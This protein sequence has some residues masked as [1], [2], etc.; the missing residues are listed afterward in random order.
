ML[1]W[2]RGSADAVAAAARSDGPAAADTEEDTVIGT[3]DVD[4]ITKELRKDIQNI[5]DSYH[6]EPAEPSILK[7][8]AVKQ[9]PRLQRIL[10]GHLDPEDQPPSQ[11]VRIFV[12]STF[13]DTEVERNWF[14]RFCNPAIAAWCESRLG[15][16]FQAVDMRW[17]VRDEASDEHTTVDLCLRELTDCQTKSR[18]LTVVSLQAQK[19]GF[20]P[21][22]ASI[23]EDEYRRLYNAVATTQEKMLLDDW[24]EHDANA[25]PPAYVLKNVSSYLG[26]DWM[27]SKEKRAQWNTIYTSIQSS[28]RAAA[29]ATL[30][31][32]RRHLYEMSV[33]EAEILK[34]ILEDPN[35]DKRCLWF[36]RNFLGLESALKDP[37]AGRFIDLHPRKQDLDKDVRSLH[38]KLTNERMAKH[39][40]ESNIFEYSLDWKPRGL[41][42][43]L[44]SEHAAYAARICRDYC[45]SVVDFIVRDI[46]ASNNDPPVVSESLVH[47]NFARTLEQEAYQPDEFAFKI[48]EYIKSDSRSPLVL[49]GAG[50]SGR[51]VAAACAVQYALTVSDIVAAR[52]VG[53][54]PA[55]AE[56]SPLL[57]SICQQVINALGV[58][59]SELAS[60]T[61][62]TAMANEWYNILEHAAATTPE[63]QIVVL[64]DGIE[65]LR[66]ADHPHD[67]LWLPGVIPPNIKLILSLHVESEA[68]NNATLAL[69][70]RS[71]Y[72]EIRPLRLENGPAVLKTLMKKYNR[73]LTPEQEKAILS[74]FNE[75][76]CSPLY[77]RI[78]AEMARTWRS[79]CCDA[80]ALLPRDLPGIIQKQFES[81]E[82]AHGELLVSRAFGYICASRFGLALSELLDLLNKDEEVLSSVFQ[83]WTP[84]DRKI[85]SLLWSR[86]E[87]DLEGVLA[88]RGEHALYGWFSRSHSIEAQKRYMAT[89]E[90]QT[91]YQEGL[92]KHF[93]SLLPEDHY[94]VPSWRHM[95]ELLWLL[96]KAGLDEDLKALLLRPG[97]MIA[98]LS[99]TIGDKLLHDVRHAW[100]SLGMTSSQMGDLILSHV[101]EAIAPEGITYAQKRP[102]IDNSAGLLFNLGALRQSVEMRKIQLEMLGSCDPPPLEHE[103]G[104][105]YA[106]LGGAYGELFE[107]EK[108]LEY[109]SKAIEI[110]RKDPATSLRLAHTLLSASLAAR[111]IGRFALAQ[112]FLE[113][114][115]QLYLPIVGEIDQNVAGAYMNMAL[116]HSAQKNYEEALAAAN[117]AI[118]IKEK[119]FGKAHPAVAEIMGN[120]CFYLHALKREDEA[121]E[122]GEAAIRIMTEASQSHTQVH[123]RLLYNV[124]FAYE[125][126]ERLE[127]ARDAY[128]RAYKIYF[129]NLG[130]HQYTADAYARTVR[131]RIRLGDKS[132]FLELPKI[133]AMELEVLKD[134]PGLLFDE[135][136]DFAELALKAN[137]LAVSRDCWA[138]ALPAAIAISPTHHMRVQLCDDLLFFTH[139]KATNQDLE[140]CTHA[141]H[142]HP[143]QLRLCHSPEKTT[144]TLNVQCTGCHLPLHLTA[145]CCK[146]CDTAWCSA[147]KPA[148]HEHE[149]EE[150]AIG[151]AAIDVAMDRSCDLCQRVVTRSLKCSD[152][153]CDFDVCSRCF[154]KI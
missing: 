153:A 118:L 48:K 129:D 87:R 77:L 107:F 70:E 131:L 147:C 144:G 60:I 59:N 124:G 8:G 150:L 123:G 97:V 49:Y 51:T 23:P 9:S 53:V 19:Y 146:S 74:R 32:E 125:S 112:E 31:P 4:V 106:N 17:G 56:I 11:I 57:L 30:S 66:A 137:E 114:A 42:P 65:Q 47:M 14:M 92:I 128:G 55:S 67:M 26:P 43:D 149:V 13:T 134:Q 133:L 38:H 120:K 64:I 145:L 61:T 68:Y 54:T 29:Q 46:T 41:R 100:F 36:R 72:I 94:A 83:H 88:L 104:S 154:A 101:R 18:S 28:L 80:E 12:S 136:Y 152:P 132:G 20:R 148:E 91:F 73:K 140:D 50:G 10:S 122:V 115:L 98:I 37:V 109:E 139:A 102:L 63:K 1:C 16:Q 34:G 40:P 35:A 24:F 143:L 93:S 25:V 103:V 90:H 75:A 151:I 110:F 6:I 117:K 105:C 84:P 62:S 78:A 135:A 5:L 44:Y 45:K 86:L 130:I 76:D 116:V 82:R 3:V 69:P 108:A 79:T 22:P 71:S 21:F 95:E 81:I 126:K 121:I 52:F 119:V 2:R 99:E 111:G 58:S 7:L 89:E 15:V 142:P 138:I 96:E 141:S 85:P 39:L 113:E 127:D 33:T 27:G